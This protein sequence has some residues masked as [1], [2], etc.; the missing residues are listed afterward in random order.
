R[1]GAASRA[2]VPLNGSEGSRFDAWSSA[3]M[4]LGVDF[5][6]PR[7]VDPGIDLRGR[8]AG[9]AEQGLNR[10]KIAAIGEKMGCKRMA[11]GVRGCRFRQAELHANPL[12][13]PLHQARV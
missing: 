5:F 6:E 12:H 7:R 9:M 10:A 8:E 1:P 11:Q 3:W 13:Q 4:R 2:D